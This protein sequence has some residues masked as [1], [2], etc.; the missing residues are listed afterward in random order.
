[1]WYHFLIGAFIGFLVSGVAAILQVKR[2]KFSKKLMKVILIIL[3]V[4]IPVVA[5][6]L[7]WRVGTGII[8]IWCIQEAI[9]TIL[10][11]VG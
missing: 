1:M 2:K 7:S 5:F 6:I 8:G 3:L 11:R 10:D 9:G 4:I